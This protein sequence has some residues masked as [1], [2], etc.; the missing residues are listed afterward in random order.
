MLF[1]RLAK[2][3]VII[4]ISIF[5]ALVMINTAAS[6]PLWIYL[7]SF[8]I[9]ALLTF[10]YWQSFSGTTICPTCKGTGKI[11]VQHGREFEIDV[12]YS[13]D[14]EGRVPVTRRY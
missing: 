7:L 14:G 3:F 1:P 13:C 4:L 11:E 2:R 9:A 12:C 10:L 8:P 5:L 6:I